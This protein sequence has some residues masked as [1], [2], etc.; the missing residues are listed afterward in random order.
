MVRRLD[1]VWDD[2]STARLVKADTRH[3][4][5]ASPQVR[6]FSDVTWGD[7]KDWIL[8]HEHSRDNKG[9]VFTDPFFLGSNPVRAGV[10]VPVAFFQ[11]LVVVDDAR[12]RLSGT[13]FGWASRTS[14]RESPAAARTGGSLLVPGSFHVDQLKVTELEELTSLDFGSL[15]D[16][17][18]IAR[19]RSPCHR[20]ALTSRQ[21]ARWHAV[22][23][24]SR[25]PA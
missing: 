20:D 21:R 3:Y 14:C 9:N 16:F 4:I 5:E 7:P 25:F 8:S 19:E 24:V 18:I 6:S 10:Q 23:I 11:V 2:E 12:G 17:D 1:P 15:R 22:G 13:A